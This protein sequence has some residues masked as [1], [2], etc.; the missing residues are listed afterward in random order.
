MVLR[1][2]FNLIPKKDVTLIAAGHF[3]SRQTDEC[4]RHIYKAH[5][6]V[7]GHAR[8]FSGPPAFP[9]FRNANNQRAVDSAGIKEAFASREHTAVVGA[10]DDDGVIGVST[11]FEIGE[12]SSNLGIH[13]LDCID[14]GC[15]GHSHVG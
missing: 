5:D 10:V 1:S 12:D 11:R 14:V 8:L 3:S 6:P 7:H 15:V 9:F 2:W 4:F 13:L